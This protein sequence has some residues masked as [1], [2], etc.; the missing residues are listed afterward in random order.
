MVN[1]FFTPGS[2]A[3]RGGRIRRFAPAVFGITLGVFPGVALDVIPAVILDR[4]VAGSV[5]PGGA[6]DFLVRNIS[7]LNSHS[8]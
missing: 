6:R 4:P 3:A 8:K 5:R 2:A 1:N 7:S